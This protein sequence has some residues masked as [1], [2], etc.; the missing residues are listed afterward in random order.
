MASVHLE[1]LAIV[2]LEKL[3]E[4]SG[5]DCKIE[6]QAYVFSV[7]VKVRRGRRTHYLTHLENNVH[8]T[9]QSHVKT[10]FQTI[11]DQMFLGHFFV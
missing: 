11:R 10:Q 4:V 1:I 2:N 9:A 8:S 3:V 5:G 6:G 7:R